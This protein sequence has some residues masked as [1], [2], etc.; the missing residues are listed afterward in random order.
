MSEITMPHD[1][2]IERAFLGSAIIDPEAVR[3]LAIEPDD[4]Y[5]GKHNTIWDAFK[6]IQR[7]GQD[8]DISIITSELQRADRLD[9]VGGASY[10]TKLAVDCVTSQN[11]ETYA[12]IIRE[13]SA[14]RKLVAIAN[15]LATSSFNREEKVESIVSQAITGM[16]NITTT[17]HQAQPFSYWAGMVYDEFDARLKNPAEVWGIPC[18]LTDLDRITGGGHRGTV[19]LLSGDPGIGKTLLCTQR[20]VGMAT[21]GQ[22]PGF[23]ASLE[24]KGQQVM[25][26]VIS[27]ISGVPTRAINTGKM[28][29]EDF[30]LFLHGFEQAGAMPIYMDDWR[31]H[32]TLTIRAECH[33][34]QTLYGIQWVIL[35]YDELLKDRVGKDDTERS[36][37]I[38]GELQRLAGDLNLFVVAIHTKNKAGL[39][40][41]KNLGKAGL[42]G[43][44]KAIYDADDIWDLVEGENENAVKMIRRKGRESDTESNFVDLVKVKNGYGENLPKF[45]MKARPGTIIP[46][47]WQAQNAQRPGSK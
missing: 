42:G 41:S 5:L 38:S 33:R 43:S 10:L 21:I 36:K 8:V 17:N 44:V 4:F 28:R 40:Q 22:T 23:I 34:L 12:E 7:R 29:D 45:G 6:R 18:G 47:I 1:P 3:N 16:T 14:R 39:D 15:R 20:G 46:D 13:Y 30:P 24:V 37:F 27:S 32:T 9:Y 19:E 31:G 26:R 35:D 25:R 2:E 11:A